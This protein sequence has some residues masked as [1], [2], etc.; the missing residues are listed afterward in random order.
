RYP[1]VRS[2][3]DMFTL[4]FSFRPWT[5][6]KAIADGASILRYLRET[7]AELG[8]DR[9]IRFGRRVTTAA[10]SSVQQ[11]WTVEVRTAEGA[12]EQ[13]T[14]AFLH[15]CSG[16]FRYDEGYTPD[17]PGLSTF[18]GP[19]VHPQAW[20]DDLDVAGRRVVVIGSGATAVTLVPALAERGAHVTMLQRSPTWMIALPGTDP[21]SNALRRL[22]PPR[23][24]NAAARWK[25][26][27]F[28]QAFFQICLHAPRLGK[29]MLR[30]GLARVL[31]DP[32]TLRTD[33]APRYDPWD[34]RLCVVPDGDLFRAMR[35][36]AAEVVTDRITTV[37]PTGVMTASGR[38]LRADVLVTATGLQLVAWGG[39]AVTV[40][41]AAVDPGETVAYRGCLVSEVPNLA[42]CV[43][44]VNASWTL[45]ADL[46]ARYVTRLLAYMDVHGYAVA[47]PR[48]PRGMRTRPLLDLS[49]G[50]IRRSLSALPRQGV[51]SPW[52]LRQ[53]YLRD[54]YEMDRGDVAEDMEFT[55][56]VRAAAAVGAPTPP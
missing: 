6:A 49:S 55:A 9:R 20:P 29:R 7:A 27:L 8:I 44:Y 24:G 5:E 11:R 25:N 56:A 54:R 34:Q 41:G 53:N 36:G 28:T 4:G 32:T 21:L 14:C 17:I 13:W 2:D 51:R 3:S 10:W 52:S 45:R 23:L 39:I 35:D 12:T 22:L 15:L 42:F 47:T 46:V 37:T 16:Y 18:G 38:E 19:V 50:Y 26:I 40:D 31:P 30:A 48:L 1:G 43:G 33:F